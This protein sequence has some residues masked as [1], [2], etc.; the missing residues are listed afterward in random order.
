MRQTAAL[1]GASMEALSRACA[2]SRRAGTAWEIRM[3]IGIG[4]VILV[5]LLYLFLR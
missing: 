1:A 2:T 5:I 3:Y 4:T